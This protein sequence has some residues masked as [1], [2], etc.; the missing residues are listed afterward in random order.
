MFFSELI[1]KKQGTFVGRFLAHMNSSF[2]SNRW[3][4]KIT[5]RTPSLSK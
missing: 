4:L 3:I 2:H 1:T 5:G